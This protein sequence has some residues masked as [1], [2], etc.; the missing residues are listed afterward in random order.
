[1][2]NKVW[3][4]IDEQ[5]TIINKIIKQEAK[6]TS[7]L[8][9]SFINVSK[10]IIT[11]S[12][13]SYNAAKLAKALIEKNSSKP[14]IIETPFH[15]RYYSNLL[16]HNEN[17]LLIV[18]SQT[19]KSVGTLE[20][21][22]LAKAN[23]IP[24]IALTSDDES[25]IAKQAN[26]HQNILCGNESVGPK[27]KGF[28]ATVLVL[29]LLLMKILKLENQDFLIEYRNSIQD[30]PQNSQAIK[31]WYYHH[32][33]WSKDKTMSITGFGINYPTSLE[34]SLKILETMQISIM[35]YEL[36]EFMHGPHR[37][38][39][40]DSYI[41]LIDTPGPGSELMDNLI[42]FIKSKTNNY[43]VISSRK[44]TSNNII[45]VN[46]YSLT[47][48]WFNI[49]VIFQ[50]ICTYLPEINGINSS[51]PIYGDFATTVGTRIP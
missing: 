44:Q 47:S 31:N 32:Q 38:I 42:E 10:I 7:L 3:D 27:T 12:G 24:V 17:Y 11:A 21:L 26:Y 16:N 22:N 40:N 20:C 35:N 4:Y 8:P 6:I 2:N 13:S 50:V 39:V 15:L 33:N 49:L 29:Q 1:M 43:L 45:N 5:P 19:G 25:P 28:S 14:I 30:L 36:E 9:E 48:S 51:N 41:I 37:T 46:D 34:G 18:L 23:H